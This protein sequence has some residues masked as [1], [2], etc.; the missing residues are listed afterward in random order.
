MSYQPQPGTIAFRAIEWLKLQP[1]GTEV[2]AS[3]WGEALDVEPVMIAPCLKPAIHAGLVKEGTRNGMQRPK[4]YRLGDGAPTRTAP[5][6]EDDR[7]PLPQRTS[8]PDV[9]PAPGPLLP[10]VEGAAPGPQPE[11]MEEEPEAAK[12]VQAVAEEKS[13]APVPFDCWLSGIS[14]ELVLQ[15]VAANDE[16]DLVLTF[17]Q[18]DVVRRLLAGRAP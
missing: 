7:D 17:E 6:D 11:P 10:G 13:A 2:T 4:W 15:G 12:D 18:V 9:K 16:G 1:Q 8:A 3:M 14:G 5:P